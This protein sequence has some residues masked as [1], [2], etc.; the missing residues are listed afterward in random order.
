MYILIVIS[1]FHTLKFS[2]IVAAAAHPVLFADPRAELTGLEYEVEPR[3]IVKRQ[4]PCI[5]LR[6]ENLNNLSLLETVLSNV[7]KN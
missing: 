2:L 3:R 1:I 4:T 7:S 5:V 6:G